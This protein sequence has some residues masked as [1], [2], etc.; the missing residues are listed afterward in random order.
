MSKI[1][2]RGGHNSSVP[3]AKALIDEV[4]E[5]RKVYQS[6]IKYLK[7]AGKTVYDVTSSIA[8]VSA[9]LVEGVTKANNLKVDLFVSIHFNKAYNSYNGAIGTEVWVNTN[10]SK[11]KEIGTRIVNNIATCGFKNRGVKNGLQEGLYEIRTTN[12]VGIIVEVCFVEATKDVEIYKRVGYDTIGKKIAEAI[13]GKS[14]PSKPT[15]PP[16][17]SN[18]PRVL[19]LT[20]PLMYGEDVK[21]L[22]QDLVTLGLN[23]KIDSYYGQESADAVKEFQRL[24][25]WLK[26]DSIVE[27]Q[28]RK[29]I[30]DSVE[31]KK[32]SNSQPTTET[33][34]DNDNLYKVQLGSFKNRS[35]AD[36]LL[37]ELESKG[38]EGYIKQE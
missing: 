38:I 12:M 22:Q 23:V 9:E 4:V 24:H 25:T 3:G 15:T 21:E 14:I 1:A 5:D 2:I 16:A 36:K 20:T 19:K 6:V 10:D 13:I 33:K 18:Q 28:T 30:Q 29:A 8:D 26:Q 11:A 37:K 7:L 17:P 35:N 32:K 27:E 34:S 31:A